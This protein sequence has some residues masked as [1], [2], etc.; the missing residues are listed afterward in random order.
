MSERETSGK[1][2]CLN[3]Y[4]K[5]K[6]KEREAEELEEIEDLRRQLDSLMGDIEIK[7]VFFYADEYGIHPV[8]LSPFEESISPE[9]LSLISDAFM[10][11]YNGR[12]KDEDE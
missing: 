12:D 3:T 4:R 8:E 6:E 1:V 7:P 9:T 2:V 11:V 10:N 5:Q